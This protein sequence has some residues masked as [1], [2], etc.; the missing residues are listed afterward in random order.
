MI[1][2]RLKELGYYDYPSI[3]GYFGTVTERALRQF[4]AQCGLYIDAKAGKNTRARLFA[5]D[6]PA[7]DGTDRLGGANNENTNPPDDSLSTVD[8]MLSFAEQQLGKKYVY[9][10]EGPSTFDCSG[11]VYYVLKYMGRFHTAIQRRRFLRSRELA[12]DHG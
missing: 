11:F 4:Q 5:D 1:Q 2:T 12:K 6:A 10:T 8:K 9:S 7:W 3:T